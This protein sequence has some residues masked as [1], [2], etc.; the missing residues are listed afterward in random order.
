MKIEIL[1]K[2]PPLGE[3]KYIIN[4]YVYRDETKYD[5]F[6]CMKFSELMEKLKALMA[7][8][9]TNYLIKKSD[10]D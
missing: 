2:K 9:Q 1:T 4:I 8:Y 10:D 6:Y 5:T 7:L 3:Y